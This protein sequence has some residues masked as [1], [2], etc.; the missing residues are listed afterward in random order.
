[1]SKLHFL[2]HDKQVEVRNGTTFLAAARQG[3]IM[4]P[5]KCGGRG[6]CT[7]CKVQ[8]ESTTPLPEFSRM[9]RHMLGE[10]QRRA[11]YRLGCQCKVTGDAVVTI[12]EDPLRRTIRL[13]LEAARRAAEGLDPEDH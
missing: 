4:L 6:A 11:G 3:K 8:I 10:M 12:P 7:T 2:P 1:M 9:E 13:Q 5:S